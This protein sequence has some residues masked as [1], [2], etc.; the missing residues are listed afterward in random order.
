MQTFRAYVVDQ[1]NGRFSAGVRE[2]TAHDLPDGEVLIRVHYSSVNYKDGICSQPASRLVTRYPMV[3]GI[4]LSGEVVES[5]DPRF[6]AGD[7]VICTSYD[8]GTGHFGG[9]SEYARVPADW[10]VPLPDGLTLREAMV[11]GTAGFT[12]ALSLY[13]MEQNGVSPAMGP[14][15]VTGATGGVGATGIAI[16]KQAGYH[17]VASSRKEEAAPWLASLG[18]DETVHPE[19][20]L[21][22]EGE[23]YLNVKARYAGVIDPVS[24]K[25]V[26]HLLQRLEYGGVIA[27]SGYTG[28]PDFTASVFPFLRRQAAIIGIDSVWLGMETRREIWRRLA[29]P[30]KP[31]EE[32]LERI[33]YDIRLD[34]LDGALKQILAGKMKGRAVVNL[35]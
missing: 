15:L 26:P 22:K 12:A 10:V 17:V 19:A 6:H 33:G 11:L 4:D 1:D 27:I 32:A 20:L 21:L 30:W 35:L 28:G 18:A 8:L 24:G 7:P 25:Y 23:S 16:A 13:R 5:S 34:D 3:L 14:I 9:F 31:A 2:L 29:G